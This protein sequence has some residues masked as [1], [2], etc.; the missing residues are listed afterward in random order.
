MQLNYHPGLLGEQGLEGRR[1]RGSAAA[2]A[3]ALALLRVRH[4]HDDRRA[5]VP[6]RVAGRL[7]VELVLHA[8]VEVPDA[9]D[10]KFWTLV[11]FL[12]DP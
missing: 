2:A 5:L 4:P 11:R 7:R 3:E 1:R 10:C 8:P 12:Q 6:A 9:L